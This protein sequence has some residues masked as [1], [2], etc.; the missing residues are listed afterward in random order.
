MENNLLNRMNQFNYENMSCFQIDLFLIVT[1]DFSLNDLHCAVENKQIIN[2]QSLTIMCLF[3]LW[4]SGGTVRH[5][6]PMGHE[7]KKCKVSKTCE[8]FAYHSP[9]ARAPQKGMSGRDSIEVNLLIRTSNRVLDMKDWTKSQP[10]AK[11]RSRNECT[12]LTC[13]WTLMRH[14]LWT[15]ILMNHIYI[16]GKWKMD[17]DKIRWSDACWGLHMTVSLGWRGFSSSQQESRWS[18]YVLNM[19]EFKGE[20]PNTYKTAY[21]TREKRKIGLHIYVCVC[22]SVCLCV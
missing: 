18:I 19:K 21:A 16:S 12:T 20:S 4:I 9:A 22:L 7:F 13:S 15:E 5:T 11:R 2:M 6:E 8:S 14:V 17:K 10:T 3:A 1:K